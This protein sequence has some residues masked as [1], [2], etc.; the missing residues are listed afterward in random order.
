M[1]HG[2]QQGPFDIKRALLETYAV[3]EQMNQHLLE[4]LDERSWRAIPPNGKGR[5]ISAIAAHIHNVRVMCLKMAKAP[6]V[7]KQLNRH[8]LTRKEALAGLTRSHHAIE[9]LLTESL[10]TNGRI[11][12]FP[13]DVV[14]FVGRL[15]CHDAHHRG[16]ICTIARET[17][18]PLSAEATIAM[19]DWSKLRKQ[20]GLGS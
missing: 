5:T 9:T 13:P 3:N 1:P 4:N 2:Q 14:G 11:K 19:W 20:C 18:Y 6:M 17:G 10:A 8:T 7:P 12:G 15:I 16:Q